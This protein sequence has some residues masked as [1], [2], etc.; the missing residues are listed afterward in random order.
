MKN[1]SL[2]NLVERDTIGYKVKNLAATAWLTFILFS[3]LVAVLWD[4]GIGGICFIFSLIIIVILTVSSLVRLFF[5][6]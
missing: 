1:Q 3:F 6:S 5:H 2:K 4:T